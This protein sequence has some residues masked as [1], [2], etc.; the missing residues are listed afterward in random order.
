[1]TQSRQVKGCTWGKDLISIDIRYP[2]LYF[3]TIYHPNNL[4]SETLAEYN[5]LELFADNWLG[6]AAQMSVLPV[7]AGGTGRRNITVYSTVYI[8][9]INCLANTIYGAYVQYSNTVCRPIPRGLLDPLSTCQDL[10]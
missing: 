5:V 9:G 3:E 2:G 8:N 1:M 10:G 7:N 6:A 4:S